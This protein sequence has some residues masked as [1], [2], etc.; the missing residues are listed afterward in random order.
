MVPPLLRLQPLRPPLLPLGPATYGAA[1]LILAATAVG[2]LSPPL[3]LLLSLACKSHGSPAR[4]N[5]LCLRCRCPSHRSDYHCVHSF[6]L[7]CYPAPCCCMSRLAAPVPLVCYRHATY[8]LLLVICYCWPTTQ[9]DHQPELTPRAV[10]IATAFALG[11]ITPRLLP[12]S[13]YFIFPP[14]S[15]WSPTST[16]FML[17]GL[18]DVSGGCVGL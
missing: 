17:G 9:T 3:L 15:L 13:F 5:P 2:L 7:H 12:P 6:N 10:A 16:I 1:A 4:A 11:W 8:R 14:C 18:C